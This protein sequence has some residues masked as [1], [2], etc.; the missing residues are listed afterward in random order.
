[1]G[2][3]SVV[4]VNTQVDAGTAN[5]GTVTVTKP[6]GLAVGDL[7]LAFMTLNLS[8]LTPPSGW[9][10]LDSDNATGGASFNNTV[11]WKLAVAGDVSATNF[12]WTAGDALSPFCGGISA[13]RDVDQTT[14]ID[15]VAS[16]ADTTTTNPV[17]GT[18]LVTTQ[19]ALVVHYRTIRV[20]SATIST[21]TATGTGSA[22]ERTD[23]GNHGASTSYAM[24]WYDSGTTV[25]AGTITGIAVT[26]SG[27]PT[28]AFSRTIG[29]RAASLDGTDTGTF[30][31][32]NTLTANVP[33]SQTGTFTESA[34]PP[35]STLSS[36]DS[37]TLTETQ[38][39]RVVPLADTITATES[40]TVQNTTS[41]SDSVTGTSGQ[42]LTA[43]L[44]SSDSATATE[45]TAIT[46]NISSSDSGTLT[47]NQSV[48]TGS[49]PSSSDSITGTSGQSLVV[50]LSSSDS[51]TATDS[52][53]LINNMVLSSADSFTATEFGSVPTPPPV[54]PDTLVLGPGSIFLADFGA[55]EPTTTGTPDPLVWTDLGG[56]LGGVDL[57][58]EEDY[59]II[60]LVQLPDTQIRRLKK[61]RLTVKTQ[62]AE[63]TLQ[64]LVYVLNELTIAVVSGAGYNSYSASLAVDP[65]TPL[66]YRAVIV[67]G[68]KPGYNANRQHKR[69]TLI[70]RKGLS[71]DNVEISYKKD[72]QSTY[73]VT[74]ACHYVDGSTSPFK[75]I[76]EN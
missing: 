28:N 2:Y 15:G 10:Q 36:S 75:V 17:T 53:T 41:S 11:Y 58:I 73:T 35:S 14:P 48:F 44:S 72:D 30:T 46:A 52:Q 19:P 68:W 55:V 13:Y 16:S 59:D 56:I 5:V 66:T 62:L 1:M 3:K 22:N 38:T 76:D 27:T 49:N 4:H 39:T 51:V 18:S 29:I 21:F 57:S 63:P 64:N 67:R 47:E 74:W 71:V 32:N 26:S 65:A 45:A 37:G 34:N 61:R 31:E 24:A 60:E 23:F 8:G 43:N 69:R 7:M 70:I 20:A 12:T 6:T 25:V 33:S 54:M 42:S 50:N 40:A 9:T